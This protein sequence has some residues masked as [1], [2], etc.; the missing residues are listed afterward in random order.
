MATTTDDAT[1]SQPIFHS[2]GTGL[3]NVGSYQVSG[4][5][6]VTG[7]Q[8]LQLVTNYMHRLP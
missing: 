8:K 6:F 4:H 5:P 7:H 1:T 3:R 2:H